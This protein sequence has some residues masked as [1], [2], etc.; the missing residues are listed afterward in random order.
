M[1]RGTLST[2][3]FVA[4]YVP[5]IDLPPIII[6]T[7][8]ISSVSKYLTYLVSRTLERHDALPEPSKE[9]N[10]QFVEKC[11]VLKYM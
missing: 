3:R 11:A 10:C 5:R 4:S 6:L 7:R 1:H 9:R 2:A 8:Y